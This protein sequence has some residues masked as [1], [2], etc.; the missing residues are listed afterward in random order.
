MPR[1]ATALVALVVLP[2]ALA[3]PAWAT[4]KGRASGAAVSATTGTWAAVPTA[5][6]VSSPAPGSD[7]TVNWSLLDSTPRFG[8]VVNTGTFAL[9]T[10][11]YALT[12]AGVGALTATIRVEAC[13]GATWNQTANTCAGT[14][15]AL[16]TTAVTSTR[17][18]GPGAGGAA[19]S[20][21][22]TPTGLST[23]GVSSASLTVSTSRADARAA[24]TTTS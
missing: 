21:R 15:T 2:V 16:T 22:F 23:L 17:S 6:G 24:T 10:A 8:Q 5:V 1:T 12:K 13:V 9:P 4:A 18:T 14:V 11:T 19:L 7:Y 20:V 3:T